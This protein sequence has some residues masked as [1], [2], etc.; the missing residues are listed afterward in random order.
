MSLID[1]ERFVRKFTTRRDALNA[2]TFFTEM[3]NAGL[4]NPTHLE[5]LRQELI[6]DDI[7]NELPR[8]VLEYLNNTT[9]SSFR[10][11]ALIEKLC[12]AVP[13]ATLAQFQSI[14]LFK[15]EKW[16]R[17]EMM[18]QYLTPKTLFGSAAKFY[19]YLD[20]ATNYWITKEK[21]RG[22]NILK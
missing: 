2:I 1:K 4:Y 14:I 22:K 3:I 20:E 15:F 16:G 21:E 9:G 6:S 5:N 18:K 19:N 11:T 10:Q 7:A 17:D 12:K 13:K 8:Q